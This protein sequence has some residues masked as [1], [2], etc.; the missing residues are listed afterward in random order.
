MKR[1]GISLWTESLKVR[2]SKSILDFFTVLRFYGLYDGT[3]DVYSETSG[4]Y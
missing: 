2:K 4:T 1:L 3:D